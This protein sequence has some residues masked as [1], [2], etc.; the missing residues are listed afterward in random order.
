MT[1]RLSSEGQKACLQGL[2][3]NDRQ[4]L[5]IK[6]QRMANLGREYLAISAECQALEH[7]INGNVQR[8]RELEWVTQ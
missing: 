5:L 8:L 1:V 3:E 2:I 6:Y 7:H 4:S